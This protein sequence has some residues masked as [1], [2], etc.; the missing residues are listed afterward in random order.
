[1]QHKKSIILFCI[2][3]FI[4]IAHFMCLILQVSFLAGK[5]GIKMRFVVFFFTKLKPNDRFKNFLL[6]GKI[7]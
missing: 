4:Y 1:M 7:C 5:L 2:E 6:F 3:A